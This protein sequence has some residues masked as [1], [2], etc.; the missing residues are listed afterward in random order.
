VLRQRG[1]LP[2]AG[3]AGKGHAGYLQCHF[4]PRYFVLTAAHALWVAGFD[5]IY[6][7]QDVDFDRETGLYAIPA[8]FG[9]LAARLIAIL[10]HLGALTGLFLVPLFWPLSFWYL[11]GAAIATVLLL[12]EH[13]IA[14]G[15][16][17]GQTRHIRIAS[18]SINE[19]VPL[20]I[21]G[22]TTLGVYF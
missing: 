21:L 6:A 5:I 2:G 7:L 18:Y 1:A 8:E 10:S 20:V 13:I 14:F 19:I 22:G 4:A 11:G 12:A 9:P 15:Y 3:R 16:K 17:G